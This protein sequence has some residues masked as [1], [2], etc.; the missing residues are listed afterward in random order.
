M[1]RKVHPAN[2][3]DL[4]T[5]NARQTAWACLRPS[6]RWPGAE[7]VVDHGRAGTATVGG[8]VDLARKPPGNVLSDLQT[9]PEAQRASCCAL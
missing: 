4:A 9:G 6:A 3:P 7:L 5:R 2:H 1:L 8:R